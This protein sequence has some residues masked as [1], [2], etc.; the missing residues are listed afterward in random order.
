MACKFICDNCGKEQ[1]AVTV[2][3]NYV[4]PRSWYQRRDKDTG[5]IQDACCRECAEKANP[6]AL[7]LP[8]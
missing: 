6:D 2:R 8:W 1:E 3:G 7:F 4:K 5:K